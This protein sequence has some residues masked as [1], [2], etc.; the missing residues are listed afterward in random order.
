[1]KQLFQNWFSRISRFNPVDCSIF[2]FMIPLFVDALFHHRNDDSNVSRLYIL[3][4]SEMS[5]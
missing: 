1:M 5:E 2:L 3:K 4:C